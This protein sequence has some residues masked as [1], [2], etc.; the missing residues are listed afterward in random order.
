M[1]AINVREFGGPGVLLPEEVPDPVAGRDQI[2]VGLAA[3]DVIYLDTLLRSGWGGET[4]PIEPPYVPGGGG[5]GRVL[6]VGEGVDPSWVG[7]RVV[8]RK[9]GG[10]YA[11]RV[12]ADLVAVVEIPH[13]VGDWEAAATIHDGPTA[14]K[15]ARLGEFRPGEWVLVA[16]AA[17]GAGTWVV[18]L[19]RDAGARVIAAARGERKLALARDLGA[20]VTVDYSRDDWSE[21]VVAATGGAGVVV[22]FD[23]VGGTLGQ[24]VFE[25][26]ARG[27]RFITYGTAGGG[28]TEIDP[29]LAERRQVTVRNALA[30]GPPD[31]ETAR[32]LVAEA[33]A[34]VA[35]GRTHPVI[36]ATYPLDRA[37]DA[38]AS[39]AERTTV[40]KS[41]LTI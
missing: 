7:R 25:T 29:E 39:L 35:Q 21:R 36:G 37:R 19:A 22:A 2:V 11:E 6:S 24:A 33:L 17:G 12:A 28:F 13:G 9:F 18:Q 1:R 16:A 30:D 41:L 15:L 14:V 40:G 20:E 31:Q 10:G 32:K 38:H 5:S 23:G 4:F 34:L 27:G 26:V 3:A 8:V